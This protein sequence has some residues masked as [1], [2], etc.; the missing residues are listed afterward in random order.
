MGFNFDAHPGMVMMLSRWLIFGSTLVSMTLTPWTAPA[1]S[2]QSPSNNCPDILG[3][4]ALDRVQRHRIA[5]G[6]TLESIAAQYELKPETLM[7]MNPP[8]QNGLAPVGT[9]IRIPP[10]DGIEVRVQPGQSWNDLEEIYKI[11]GAAIF[12]NNGCLISPP[13][14]VFV[15]GVIW[16]STN[17]AGSR[18]AIDPLSNPVPGYPLPVEAEPLLRF[19]YTRLN[20]GT[21][22]PKFHSGIDYKAAIGTPVLAAASGVVVFVGDRGAY[23]NLIVINHADGKQTRYAHLSEIQVTVGQQVQQSQ[24][25]GRVGYSGNPDSSEPHLHFEVRATSEEGWVAENP[26]DFIRS[27]ILG[28]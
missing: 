24:Q 10:F 4:P 7:G 15:P 16:S 17:P 11:P 26:E 13:L 8:L 12:D 22:E 20:S 23:G 18:T 19:G 9:E 6:E 2:A 14:V 27:Q 5:N 1:N 21:G 28:R 25:I 3:L